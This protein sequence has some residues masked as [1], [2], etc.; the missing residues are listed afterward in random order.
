MKLRDLASNL[1]PASHLSVAGQ[2]KAVR[3][4]NKLLEK[5][6]LKGGVIDDSDH[7]GKGSIGGRKIL[8][9][10]EK[11]FLSLNTADDVKA[12]N[13]L[14]QEVLEHVKYRWTGLDMG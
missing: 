7:P 12:L 11:A 5:S 9:A 13:A 4:L 1:N 6:V 3:D 8:D 10:T 2:P 14:L